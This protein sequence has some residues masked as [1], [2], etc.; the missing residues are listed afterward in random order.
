MQ[1]R[2]KYGLRVKYASYNADKLG[3]GTVSS[4]CNFCSILNRA[5][6]LEK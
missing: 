2:K 6:I 3:T 5:I 1:D 4:D